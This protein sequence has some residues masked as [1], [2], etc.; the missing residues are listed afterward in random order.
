M[1]S[2]QLFF[3]AHNAGA[4]VQRVEASAQSAGSTVGARGRASVGAG[5]NMR[6]SVN[7]ISAVVNA[8]RENDTNSCDESSAFY[9]CN[10]KKACNFQ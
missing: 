9:R 7:A 4:N 8:G 5:G 10:D 3:F 1:L 6:G 2:Q